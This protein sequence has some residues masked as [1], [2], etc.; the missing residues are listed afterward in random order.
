MSFQKRAI[1]LLVVFLLGPGSFLNAMEIIFGRKYPISQKAASNE[2]VWK[3]I[4]FE[5]DP[6]GKVIYKLEA[7]HPNGK[8]LSYLKGKDYLVSEDI[9]KN[10]VRSFEIKVP[11]VEFD[12]SKNVIYEIS[13]PYDFKTRY[14]PLKF[15]KAGGY[16][17]IVLRLRFGDY[18]FMLASRV[19]NNVSNIESAPTMASAKEVDDLFLKRSQLKKRAPKLVEKI[20]VADVQVDDIYNALRQ[21]LNIETQIGT[22]SEIAN[23]NAMGSQVPDEVDALLDKYLP[24]EEETKSVVNP[25]QGYAVNPKSLAGSKNSL[26][27]NAK[28][29]VQNKQLIPGSF[30]SSAQQNIINNPTTDSDYQAYVD[31]FTKVESKADFNPNASID[32]II[33][34]AEGA[35]VE[36]KYGTVESSSKKGLSTAV[37]TGRGLAENST[38]EEIQVTGQGTKAGEIT[39]GDVEI[40]EKPV[41]RAV[42][43]R[44][45]IAPVNTNELFGLPDDNWTETKTAPVFVMKP[46]A[47]S[48]KRKT[49]SFAPP[50]R[51]NFVEWT[52]PNASKLKKNKNINDLFG[53]QL[54]A[55]QNVFGF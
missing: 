29:S 39:G 23:N 26:N 47:R 21:D 44:A 19:L 6:T 30:N 17:E 7:S 36:S 27:S 2:L 25:T 51:N 45:Y 13:L 31:D 34:Q 18:K 11:E 32:E 49:A 1:L 40:E 24:T 35:P 16:Q 53:E 4:E 15:E 41:R 54:K 42:K 8:K 12:S 48:K 52:P 46:K 10:M 28:E 50:A 9:Q 38:K 22:K 43:K 37:K 55:D 20:E 14:L 33:A 5:K 3:S